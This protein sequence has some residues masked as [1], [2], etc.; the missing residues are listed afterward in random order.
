MDPSLTAD[1]TGLGQL[2][3]RSRS[4]S[5][6]NG[7]QSSL[8]SSLS[9]LA[10]GLGDTAEKQLPAETSESSLGR[11]DTGEPSARHSQSGVYN[12]FDSDGE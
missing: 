12:P 2:V 7:S 4:A 9:E 3:F 11:W 6:S 10:K 1:S 8:A 5:P